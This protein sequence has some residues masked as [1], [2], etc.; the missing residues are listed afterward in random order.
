MDNSNES[1]TKIKVISSSRYLFLI[2]HFI[3]KKKKS[4][5]SLDYSYCGT[6]SFPFSLPFSKSAYDTIYTKFVIEYVFK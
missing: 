5:C 3:K 4:K 6:F 1:K 2:S